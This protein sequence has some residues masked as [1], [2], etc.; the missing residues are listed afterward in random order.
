MRK[1]ELMLVLQPQLEPAGVTGIVQAAADVIGRAGGDVSFRGQLVDR[2]GNVAETQDGWKTRRLAY[3]INGHRDGFY[4][5]LRFEAPTESIDEVERV[6]NLNDDVLRHLVL[7]LDDPLSIKEPQQPG[8]QSDRRGGETQGDRAAPSRAQSTSGETGPEA[9]AAVAAG[10]GSASE[11][12]AATP[13]GAGAAATERAEAP[14]AAGAEGE[15]A[16]TASGAD[17][18]EPVATSTSV[19][20]ADDGT[21]ATAEP[22]SKPKRSS[23]AEPVETA[24]EPGVDAGATSGP[25]G[26]AREAAS[27]EAAPASAAEE[28]P[29]TADSGDSDTDEESPSTQ[30]TSEG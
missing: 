3:A 4:A 7:R 23:K 18:A 12:A 25:D 15:G 27:E 13:D 20:T 24:V 9:G 28:G 6:L 22:Q 21:A 1:Y 29:A 10:T 2:R 11:E 5:V 17:G 19:G 8:A 14:A 26:D 30:G 16:S